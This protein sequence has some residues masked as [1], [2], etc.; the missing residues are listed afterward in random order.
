MKSHPCRRRKDAALK[1]STLRKISCHPPIEFSPPNAFISGQRRC[2]RL[3]FVEVVVRFSRRLPGLIAGLGNL[4]DCPLLFMATSLRLAHPKPRTIFYIDG[5]NLYY[6]AIRAEPALKWLNIARYCQL[7]RPNDDV[8]LIR[9][10]SALVSGPSKA[11]QE[12][13]LRALSTSPLV[14]VILGKFKEKSVMC[15]VSSCTMVGSKFYKVNEEKRTDVNVAVFILDDAYQ[16]ICDQIVIF[17]GDSDLVPAVNMVRLRFPQKK[18]IVYVPSRNPTRGA[19][20]ELRT[21]AHVNR[22]LP[23]QILSKAQFPDHISDGAGGVLTRPA[24]WK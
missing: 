15:R 4:Y 19:A 3:L 8:T 18:I 14:N 2:K 7:L 16:D 10:F 11:N 17:S 12:V 13:Y 5:F 22:T 21:S 24:M 20:V 1:T 23:L 9:Y 6:G